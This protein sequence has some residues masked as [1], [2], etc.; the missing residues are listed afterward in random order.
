[1]QT[2]LKMNCIPTGMELFP[3]ADEEQ[4]TFIK[5]VIDDCDYYLLIIGGRYGSM[6]ADGISF[7]EKEY[8]YAVE[9]GIPIIA[10]IHGN[11]E[12]IPAGKTEMDAEARQ[13]LDAFREK[14]S[15]G[16]LIDKWT[17]AEDLPAKAALSL[18]SAFKSHPAIGWVRADS[19][20]NIDLLQ[21]V[22]Q[23]QQANAQLSAELSACKGKNIIDTASLAQGKQI[24]KLKGSYK[25]D[26]GS[27]KSE[28]DWEYEVSWNSIISLL[29]PHLLMWQNESYANTLLT[30]AILKAN[31]K[32]TK[33]IHPCEISEEL[34]QTVKIQLMALG[35]I[36]VQQF[37]TISN[38]PALFWRLTEAGKVQLLKTASIKAISQE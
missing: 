33:N 22:N 36:E 27:W 29:G 5:K 9:R 30:K 4:F 15:G 24:I 10:L 20:A 26:F 18:L 37:T 6:T 2:L 31:S 21:Q 13:K 28:H 17:R 35:W 38:M 19:V 32:D 25:L 12:I 14:V 1:M 16:R 11:P 3:A 7:T 23:L 34:F 8:D